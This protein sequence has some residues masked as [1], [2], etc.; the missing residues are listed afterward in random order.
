[1]LYDAARTSAA[2]YPM[3]DP[4]YFRVCGEDRRDFVQRQTTN[5]IRHL[6]SDHPLQTVLTSATARIMDV[7]WLVEEPDGIG[8]IT[9]PGRGAKMTRYMQSRI[10]FKDRVTLESQPLAQIALIG[11][12]A[13]RLSAGFTAIQTGDSRFLLMATDGDKLITALDSAGAARLDPRTYEI[14]RIEAGLPGPDRELTEDYTP[15]EARLD[16]AVSLKKGCYT[17][18]EVLARQVNYDKIT[19]RMVGL[20]L[21]AVPEIGAKVLVEDRIVGDV[22]SAVESPRFGS[23]ALAMIRRPHHEAGTV[24]KVRNGDQVVAGRVVPIP[25]SD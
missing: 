10:F 19:R 22:T 15:L 13:A 17:G 11:P 12:D 2:F 1:M 23:I 8:V 9:L 25:F 18:Q 5:D 16:A 6:T 4:G 20:R 3:P 14:L 24:V 21:D 7:W